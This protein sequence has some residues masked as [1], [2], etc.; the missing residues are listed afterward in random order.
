[1]DLD[2]FFSHPLAYLK[3]YLSTDNYNIEDIA[4]AIGNLIVIAWAIFIIDWGVGRGS[5]S[6]ALGIRP[7]TTIGLFGILFTPFL[8]GVDYDKDNNPIISHIVFNTVAFAILGLFIGLQGLKLFYVVT[9]GI[10]LVS[11]IGTWLVGRE[12]TVHVGASGV[13]YGYTAFLFLYGF[14]SR[15]PL[16]FVLGAISFFLRLRSGWSIAGILPSGP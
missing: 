5:L 13:T 16:A 15:N 6:G 3:L 2:L 4:R 11:G 10:A 12:N 1:M 8:H 14:I 7:R 9:I